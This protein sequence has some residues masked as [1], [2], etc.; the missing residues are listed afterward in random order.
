ME[1]PIDVAA[2]LLGSQK[3][4]ASALKVSTGAVSQWK[5]DGR[6]IPAEH[7]PAIERLTRGKVR[8]EQMRPDI[9]WGVLRR[10]AA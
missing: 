1:H 2:K 10:K 5:E 9:A 4:L 3:A 7:C 6:K 8:C